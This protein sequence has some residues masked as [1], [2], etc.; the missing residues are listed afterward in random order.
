MTDNPNLSRSSKFQMNS[1][2]SDDED[3]PYLLSEH[4]LELELMAAEDLDSDL[5]L[6]FRIQ[7][8]EALAASL[9]FHPSASTSTS[10][11]FFVDSH[12]TSESDGFS[13]ISG[14]QSEELA[15]FEKEVKDL[16]ASGAEVLRLTGEL[17][18][19]IHHE[20]V[21]RQ[22]LR[23]QEE[24][25]RDWA[26]NYEKPFDYGEGSS[27]SRSLAESDEIFGLY[28]KGIVSEE[29]VRADKT[30]LAGIGVAICDSRGN[31]ILEVRK[32]LLGN[33]MSKNAAAAKALIEGLNAA[34]GLELKR[35]TIYFDYYPLYQFI[36]GR[37]LPKQ[38]KISAL[39]DEVT[40]LEEKFIYFNPKLVARNDI[41]YAFE[42][43]RDAIVSQV[44]TPA[45]SS[46]AKNLTKN[47][48]ICL[49]DT[50]I[51][52][53]FSVDGCLHQ[54]CFSCMKQ[55]VEVKLL[56][57]MVPKCPHEGC[58]SELVVESCRKFL[59]PNAIDTFSQRLREASIPVTERVYCPYPRCSTLMSKSGVLEYAKDFLDV[60]RTGARKCMK[61]HGLFCITCKV[62]WH[63]NMNCHD[64]KMLNPHP[65]S[66]DVKLK[67]LATRNLW[68]QC[69]KC[70]HMI[71][72]A[73]GCF[74]MT[75]RCGNEFCYNCGA[76]WKNK[77]ATC[78]CPLWDEDHIWL[79]QDRH[80]DEE[81]E[82]EDE[83]DEYYD[84][85]LDYY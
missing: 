29:R 52:R 59:T 77:Q 33:G 15:R 10:S 39:V 61:C 8:E 38:R 41:R 54:Y 25:W 3:L 64:Y 76:E 24:D 7:L 49:E 72:L 55:H 73:E 81:E 31:L 22:I 82:E 68:R 40:T 66:E 78:S 60:E 48:V 84:S 85:D 43:A 67:S 9:A 62:P 23:I 6:A 63:S 47:C 14:L 42:L 12:L 16:E 1:A 79:E 20:R 80:F 83:D 53:M 28:F 57:G 13:K 11:N 44:S 70:N 65:P 35:I 56:H 37:W 58:K 27:K 18:R 36:I 19:Q 46:Q 75:C 71:E 51:G 45:E 50:D 21:A 4:R 26:D 32:P 5:D 2:F 17:R 34:L 30:V 69:V 74:H